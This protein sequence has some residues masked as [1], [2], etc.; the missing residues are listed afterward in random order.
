MKPNNIY[1]RLRSS[2]TNIPRVGWYVHRS[3]PYLVKIEEI[4]SD[5]HTNDYEVKILHVSKQ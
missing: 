5:N 2:N 1:K 3:Y 4:D